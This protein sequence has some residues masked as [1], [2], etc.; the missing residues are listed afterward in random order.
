[1]KI[2]KLMKMLSKTMLSGNLKRKSIKQKRTMILVISV[3][4]VILAI[5]PNNK[6]IKIKKKMKVLEL[7]KIIK[8]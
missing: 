2:L 6:N 3:N 8:L 4:L 5:S 7:L 1:M